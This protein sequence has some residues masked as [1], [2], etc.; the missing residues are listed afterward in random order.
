MMNIHKWLYVLG[1]FFVICFM[2]NAY[3]GNITISGTVTVNNS[4][5]KIDPDQCTTGPGYTIT[6]TPKGSNE[7]TVTV[8]NVDSDT[9]FGIGLNQKDPRACGIMMT[10]QT[11]GSDKYYIA[12]IPAK[13]GYNI[14]YSPQGSGNAT[15]V[16]N[17]FTMTIN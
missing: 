2:A 5:F 11:I 17:P 16:K 4:T 10:L 12:E 13:C 8:K 9:L 3:A 15:S 6:V 1:M 14:D 7:Y